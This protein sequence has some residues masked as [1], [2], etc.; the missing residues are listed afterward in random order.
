LICDLDPQGSTT[1]YFRV[2]RKFK[3]GVKGFV[4]GGTKVDDNIKG[5]NYENL[6]LL[7]ADISYRHMDLMMDREKRSRRRLALVLKP[8]RQEYDFIFLDCPPG[9]SLVAENVFEAADHLVVPVIPTTLAVQSFRLLEKFLKKNGVSGIEVHPFFSMVERRKKM[10]RGIM[11]SMIQN[12]PQMLSE[13][14]PFRAEVEKMGIAREPVPA[15]LPGSKATK[16]YRDLWKEL[17]QSSVHN[18]TEDDRETGLP[19]ASRESSSE[20]GA[21]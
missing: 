18:P 2:R 6:D 20:S 5:T 4:H 13:F 21:G 12:N 11:D 8:L 1:Y 17:K 9:I 19:D 16:S 14:I 3:S 7:P 10:Q 15:F